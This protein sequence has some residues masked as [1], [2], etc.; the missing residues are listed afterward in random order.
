M[1][2]GYLFDLKTF[3]K[4]LDERPLSFQVSQI[5]YKLFDRNCEKRVTSISIKSVIFIFQ[6]FGWN[7]KFLELFKSDLTPLKYR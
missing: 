2:Q 4:R 3:F 7:I 6:L 5:K 1:L